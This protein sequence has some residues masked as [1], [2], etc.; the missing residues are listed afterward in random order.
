MKNH[1][2]T[3]LIFL[4]S[5][6]LVFAQNTDTSTFVLEQV[7]VKDNRIQIPFSEHSRT[8]NII[9]H[10]EIEAS[11][12]QSV[13]ELL[14]NVAGVDIRQRGAHGV[15][16]DVS[17]RGG[18]FDQTL[19]LINGIKMSDPQTGHHTLNIPIDLESVE[20]IEILKGPAARVYGQNAFA[21]AINIVTKIP[22]KKYLQFNVFGGQHSLGGA[23]GVFV[24]PNKKYKQYF[25]VSRRFS[26]GYRYNT[27]YDIADYFYQSSLK[28]RNQ[29]LNFL[30]SF[31]EKKFGAN[32]FYGND[33]DVFANQYEEVQTS[34]VSMG[35]QIVKGNFVLN[36]RISWRRNQD[37]YVFI[38]NNPSIYRNMHISNVISLELN[39]D[40]FSDFGETGFGLEWSQVYLRS[41]NL[42]KHSRSV[43]TLFLEHRLH[44]FGNKIDVTPGLSASYYSDFGTKVFPGIDVGYQIN[45]QFKLYANTGYTWRIPT[46]TDLFYEDMANRGNPNLQPESAV[47]YEL[48]LKYIQG[49]VHLQVSYF[50]RDGEKLIDW[51][52]PTA[53]DKWQPQNF[54]NLQMS[55]IDFF[56]NFD[57]QNRFNQ[58]VI[59][60]IRVGYT[61]IDAQEAKDLP[62]FSRYV[63]ENLKHQFTVGMDYRLFGKLVHSISFRYLDRTALE[64]Y[65]L[66]DTKLSW[67]HQGVTFYAQANN[68]FDV[69]YRESNLVTMPGR[70]ILGGVKIKMRN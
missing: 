19:I 53:E 62:V 3:F 26:D 29:K 22:E 7:M 30:A 1:I 40:Y 14:Q 5:S 12:A 18:T 4:A 20:R 37:K 42:G 27:D 28:Y 38:R 24:F 2:F 52:K 56:G 6:P 11:T 8:L 57:F 21:G 49:A 44:F 70:W 17:I 32:R 39:N 45:Q 33:S 47:S 55:G 31:S 65:N 51:T 35:N 60:H 34:L 58:N 48:G 64:N 36:P 68:L 50:R 61:F 10:Q 25:S 46:F 54:N 67:K 23:S 13:P 66:L 63:L 16:A 59:Q 43:A 15:Q 9:T 41:N 69:K